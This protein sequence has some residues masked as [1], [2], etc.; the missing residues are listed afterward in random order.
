MIDDE[1]LSH[2]YRVLRG[3]EVT[4]ETL[5]FE[6]IKEAVYGEGHFL[7]GMHTMNAMQRDYFWPSKL[8]DREQ[9]DAWAEQGATDMMQRANA[10]ARE[11]LAEHQPEYLSAEADRKIRERFNILL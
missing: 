3:I 4:E 5:G 7:G 6:A 9:P 8:S 11:I 10:R 1:M 2:V